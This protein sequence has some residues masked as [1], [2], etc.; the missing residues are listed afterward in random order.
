LLDRDPHG[1][2]QVSKIDTERLLILT[3]M[4]ELGMRKKSGTY[5]GT[6][7]PQS[8]FFGYEGRCALP[9]N[10]DS[11]YCYSI[12]M[13]AAYLMMNKFSGYMSC[14]KNLKDPNP[15]NWIAAGCP[16]PTMMGIERRKGKDKPVITKALVKLDG[17]MF[18]CYQAVR[19]KWAVLDC[20]QSPGPIQFK[21]PA[22]DL[23]NYMVC[24][25]EIDTFIYETDVQERYEKRVMDTNDDQLFRQESSLSALSQA[26]IKATHDIPNFMDGGNWRLTAVKKYAPSSQLVQTKINE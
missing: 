3:V 13:N 1:N 14:I 21:G 15:A 16:L 2:V 10:F 20:Y 4:A 22:S 24:D 18:K 5:N 19:A 8:H 7:M 25:P 6:F 23:S 12:G 26:R 11:N 9:S 17:G